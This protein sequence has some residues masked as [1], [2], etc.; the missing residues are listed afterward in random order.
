MSARDTA[1]SVLIACRK[2]QAWSDGTIKEYIARDGLDRRDAA[3]ASQLAYGVLQN[4][5]LLDEW[6]GRFLN[7]KIDKLQPVVTDI[8]RIAVYQITFL[9]KIP[10]SAAVN[11]AVSQCKRHA[12]PRAAGLVNAVLRNM[13][14]TPEKLELPED[15][16]IRYSHPQE[17]VN[18]LSDSI[19]KE[20]I[21]AFL[22]CDNEAP[23]TCV[24][25]NTLRCDAAA[26]EEKLRE[27]GFNVER[28]PW[29]DDCLLLSGGSIEH[30]A[31]FLS[32]AV[33]A[34]DAAAKLA[35]VCSG[36]KPG[37]TVL[38]C[39]SAP[40]GKSFAS[41][42]QMQNTGKIISCDLHAH[43]TV[44]IE[45]G[46]DRLGL[47]VIHAEQSDASVLRDDFVRSFDVV[48]ADVPCSGYGVIRKKPDIRYKNVSETEKLP[49]LQLRILDTQAAYVRP[50][51]I[52]LYSTC[53]VLKRENEE[54]CA[55]FLEAHPEYTADDLPLPYMFGKRKQLT[56]LPFEYGTDGFFIARFRRKE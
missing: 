16:C 49:A 5:M 50:G 11:E 7:C 56:L 9:D 13:L 20:H 8:L 37:D 14:R 2:K 24:Q 38:D 45:K 18:L 48:I 21:E 36:V 17:L 46:A 31:L 28:H 33:Y 26:A 40:G 32:G 19:G 41:A 29:L 1:L 42:I 3:L 54:V 6:I 55:A 10:P 44:L 12:N 34:Q 43:K 47:S 25:V 4:R 35:A 39:C 27:E 15:L 51:G 30:S 22:R 53:T 23:K 52:L